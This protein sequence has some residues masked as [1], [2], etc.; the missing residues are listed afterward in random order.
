MA[1]EAKN[2]ES[3]RWS[4]G[5]LH[6]HQGR[7]LQRWHDL[8]GLACILLRFKPAKTWYVLPWATFGPIWTRWK[9]AKMTGKRAASGTASLSEAELD[10][11]GIRFSESEGHFQ[12]MVSAFNEKS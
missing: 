6:D 7:A 2:N 10:L 12:A 5:Q 8:G 9:A 3:G 4:L 11:I 1:A